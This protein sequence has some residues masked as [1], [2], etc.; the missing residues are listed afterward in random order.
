MSIDKS[1]NKAK[2]G[3]SFGLRGFSSAS[4]QEL[5]N[6]I[7]SRKFMDLFGGKK[8]DELLVKKLKITLLGH[9]ALLNECYVREWLDELQGL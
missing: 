6:N 8:L 7:G 1:V 9:N 3:W 4:V 2:N 5:C